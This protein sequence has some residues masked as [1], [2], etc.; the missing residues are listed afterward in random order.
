MLEAYREALEAEAGAWKALEALARRQR[1]AIIYRQVNEVDELRR[2]LEEQLRLT[3]LAHQAS[4]QSQPQHGEVID[5]EWEQR[6]Q[7]AQLAA[8]EALRLNRE[9]LR[10]ACSYLEML[11]GITAREADAAAYGPT[12]AR[13]RV[14]S[15]AQSKVA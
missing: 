10:D 1:Q 11:H 9:L 6:V 5:T 15:S 4:R 7:R 13:C 3:L 2:E 14:A 12:R 8:R